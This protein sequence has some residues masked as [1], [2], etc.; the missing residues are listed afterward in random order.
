LQGS[1][2]RADDRAW[3]RRDI[4]GFTL[5]QSMVD[6]NLR[7]RAAANDMATTDQDIE[8]AAMFAA[9]GQSHSTAMRSQLSNSTSWDEMM[10]ED[11]ARYEEMGLDAR[12]ADMGSSREPDYV[13]E[14][15]DDFDQALLGLVDAPVDGMD[16]S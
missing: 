14:D 3:Q 1:R 4:E 12:L 16:M 15:D 7:Y 9:T 8:D 13:M 2:Q 10:A 5:K 6:D 11:A